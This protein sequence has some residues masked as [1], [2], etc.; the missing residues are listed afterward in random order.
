MKTKTAVNDFVIRFANVNGT[1]SA[2]ANTLIAK[3]IF[4]MGVPIGP[5][6]MFPSNIQG[7][8]TWYEIRVNGNGFTGRRG[9]VDLM[10]AFNGAT[11][12][13]DSQDVVPGGYLMYDSSK[14]LAEESR[15]QDIHYLP[16]PISDLA[17]E[18]FE[19]VNKRIFLQNVIYVGVLARLLNLDA[20]TLQGLLEAQY[21]KSKDLLESNKKAID[22]GIAYCEKTFHFPLP[23]HVELRPQS[24]KVLL[25]GNDA[26]ALAA[27]YAGATVCGWYPIT[28]STSVVEHFSRYCHK[29]RLDADGAKKFAIVQAED[30]IASIGIVLGATWNGARAFTATSGP[31]ISLMGEFL[32]Y[33][34]YAE[35]PAV[36]FNIQRCG[37]STGM[38][39]RSQ[40][41]DL[42]LCAYSS[43][44]DTKH[45]LL[46]PGTPTE[47]F[48]LGL[49]AFDLADH[50]QTPVFVLS[51]LEL[52]MNQFL[53]DPLTLDP[54]Y[55]IN[56]GKVL[57]APEIEARSKPFFRY[58]DVDGD[59]VPYR[60][61]PGDTGKGAYF[62]RGSG[63][64]RF[65]RYTESSE[66]YQE[67]LDRI[68]AKHHKAKETFPKPKWIDGQNKKW[69]LVAFG[70]TIEPLVE[71]MAVLKDEGLD[72]PLL[73]LR[74]FPFH[75]EVE[76]RLASYQNVIVVEQNQQGQM[77]TLMGAE[78]VLPDQAKIHSLLHYSGNPIEASFLCHKIRTIVSQA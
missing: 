3:T 48:E 25:E 31:G 30:E 43:H 29:Y 61:Y 5:K 53:S 33:A 47:C 10:I 51:D 11:L 2:S 58:E 73:C 21:A 76:N 77:K 45:I 6:N 57:R 74:S 35:L 52:G 13:A 14:P 28:P 18:H 40:Q 46:I 75:P 16:V 54:A 56:R 19:T 55:R 63:H 37:P 68:A 41:S 15:R 60:T 8:P 59:G 12:R 49:L 22:I 36:L 50:L 38:P 17:I 42:L 66:L 72:L 27:L 62:T 67:N 44:G 39:T 9:G 70:S 20:K 64:D 23:F 65:G 71:A 34:Y 4:R 1:G 26:L 7:L 32:G 69:V 78:G 24:D